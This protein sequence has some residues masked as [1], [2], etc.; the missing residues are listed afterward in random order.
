M[1]PP[2]LAFWHEYP[3][4]TPEPVNLDRQDDIIAMSIFIGLIVGLLAS[5]ASK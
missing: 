4:Q 2:T 5:I 1:T 3:G